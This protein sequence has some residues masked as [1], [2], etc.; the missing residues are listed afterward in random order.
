M[1]TLTLIAWL[2]IGVGIWL[3][4]VVWWLIFASGAA[5]QGKRI[6]KWEREEREERKYNQMKGL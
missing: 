6:D 5:T 2:G 1:A 3:A 4:C